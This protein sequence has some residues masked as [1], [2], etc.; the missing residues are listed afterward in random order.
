MDPLTH[1]L[2]G[3]AMA[4]TRSCRR[5]PLAL[6]T[7]VLAANGP[8]VDVFSYFVGSD[9]ALGFRR[10]W[11]H[12]PIGLVVLPLLVVA[13]VIGWDRWRRRAEES[14][15]EVSVRALV[16]LAYPAG[17]VWGTHPDSP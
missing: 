13:I 9:T 3:A 14:R 11:T 1:S 6:P 10:G 15:P 4:S 5:I 7:L 8:D 17:F 16:V 2:L 12:G